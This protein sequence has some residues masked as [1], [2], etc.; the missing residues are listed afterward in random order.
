MKSNDLQIVFRSNLRAIREAKNLSQRALASKANSAQNTISELE[1]GKASPTL[2]MIEKLC[3]ALEI[4]SDVLLTE[5]GA[6]IF[7]SAAA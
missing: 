7:L 4:D 2:A 6:E 1:S 3:Q 5:S